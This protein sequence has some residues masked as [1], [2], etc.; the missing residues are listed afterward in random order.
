MQHHGTLMI[1]LDFELYWGVHDVMRLEDYKEN[2][3]GAR[4]AVPKILELFEK[5]GIHAT[6][7]TVGLLFFRNKKEIESSLPQLRPGYTNNQF[8][9]YEKI[10]DIGLNE[11]EDPFHFAPSLIKQ[12]AASPYQEIATH[13]FSHY[14]CLEDG[15]TPAEFEADMKAAVEVGKAGNYQMKT[16]VFPRNQANAEYLAICEK[17]GLLSFRGNEQS[18]FYQ[19]S[20]Y[21]DNRFLLKRIVRLTDSYI[22]ITGHHIYSAASLQNEPIINFSSSSFLRPYQ[23]KLKMIEPLRLKRIKNSL[24]KAAKNH[25]IYH[26]WW[27]PHNFGKNLEENICFLTK[28]LDHFLLL[29]DEYDMKTLNMCEAAEA[30]KSIEILPKGSN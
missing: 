23:P 8:S 19:P 27:H 4:K 11:I 10:K 9:P 18:V 12:I 15:Q 29:K 26:L 28:I 6:W 22:N 20:D 17:Y 30:L 13:T 25:K 16:I 3:L 24:T 2:L 14:Y 21:K 1:S 5:Y 7:A